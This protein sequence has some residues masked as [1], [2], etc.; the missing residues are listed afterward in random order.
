MI[1][2]NNLRIKDLT[3]L[4]D[5]KVSQNSEIVQNTD[6]FLAR[7]EAMG[8]LMDSNKRIT[9]ISWFILLLFITIESAPLLVK[10]LASRGAYDE[11]LD[12]EHYKKQIE[13]KRI[14]AE[15]QNTETKD[16]KLKTENVNDEF[17][18]AKSLN[19]DFLQKVSD[20]Q[21]EI[22]QAIVDKWKKNEYE[23]IEQNFSE[24]MPR[25]DQIFGIQ[26]PIP[27]PEIIKNTTDGSG[28]EKLA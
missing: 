14:I 12:V 8:Q 5:K 2:D 15:I 7:M 13:A 9:M 20:A 3:V 19:N 24:I 27:S 6:G 16:N 4:R 23:K 25:I 21:K 22:N 11:L 10:L 1:S 26:T 18:T 28:K 17:E